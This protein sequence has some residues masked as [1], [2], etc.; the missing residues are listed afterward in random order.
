MV[1]KCRVIKEQKIAISELEKALDRETEDIGNS[2]TVL[3]TKEKILAE[4]KEKL[5]TALNDVQAKSDEVLRL[6]SLLD[7]NEMYRRAEQLSQQSQELAQ[8]LND[9]TSEKSV[10]TNQ[11]N[12]SNRELEHTQKQLEET[13]SQRDHLQEEKGSLESR[14]SKADGE[15]QKLQAQID[16]VL[17]Q[18]Q[19]S[20][21]EKNAEIKG[22]K[23]EISE[24]QAKLDST[25]QDRD[26]FSSNLDEMRF[27]M[28]DKT[29]AL[30]EMK[31]KSES[32][33]KKLF[34]QEGV[35]TAIQE[36]LASSNEKA[37]SLMADIAEKA[38][39]VMMERSRSA[40]LQSQI[41][42]IEVK[43]RQSN[44]SLSQKEGSLRD[45]ECDMQVRSLTQF[46]LV[47]VFHVMALETKKRNKKSYSR[48]LNAAFTGP[49]K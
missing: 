34:S 7:E 17:H 44:E 22:L 5:E 40:D 4:T 42:D 35:I 11:L 25:V 14:L 30:E 29:E 12:E 41:E 24:I 39:A 9:L 6:T 18:S 28:N 19:M 33:A 2:L 1:E 36:E 27:S 49:G 32:L 3:D 43:L 37:Q 15:V 47:I 20:N 16:Q 8:Q 45:I 21:D 46:Q 10:L 48:P 23:S 26:H 31:A 38:E 13:S